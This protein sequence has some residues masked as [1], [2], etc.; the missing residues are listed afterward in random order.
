M[1]R[2]LNSS[3]SAHFLLLLLLLSVDGD[4][5]RN[6]R[7][8]EGGR[9]IVKHYLSIGMDIFMSLLI[10]RVIVNAKNNITSQKMTRQ[11]DL[12][13]LFLILTIS[14]N[15]SSFL[16]WKSGRNLTY[17]YVNDYWFFPSHMNNSRFLWIVC[18]K[19]E[20]KSRL[21]VIDS[22]IELPFLLILYSSLL[23]LFLQ[24]IKQTSLR[25]FSFPTYDGLISKQNTEM[26]IK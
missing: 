19:K 12:H 7:K 10:S 24:N 18:F 6:K 15:S 17:E 26:N 22:C 20:E 4:A 25:N 5:W 13:A 9:E 1:I 16:R 3:F 8:K 2:L 23:F 14:V 11:T 21:F